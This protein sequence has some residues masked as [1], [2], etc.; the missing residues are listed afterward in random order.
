[1]NKNFNFS[2]LFKKANLL[3]ILLF[4]F[5]ILCISFKGLNYGIDF[6]GGTLIELRVIDN[7]ITTSDIRSSFKKLIIGDVSVKEFGKKKNKSEA[8][9]SNILAADKEFEKIP[10]GTVEIDI[11]ENVFISPIIVLYSKN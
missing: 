8:Y 7:N 10:D 4:A 6:K 5:S 1:M 2:S 3:S 11:I 9:I